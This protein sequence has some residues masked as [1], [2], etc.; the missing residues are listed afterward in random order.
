ACS[1]F[2]AVSTNFQDYLSLNCLFSSRHVYLTACKSQSCI[3]LM[4]LP[5]KNPIY[6]S[7]SKCSNYVL[8][9]KDEVI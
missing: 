4:A 3:W 9:T 1:D 7:S 6:I 2:I 5:T 8:K